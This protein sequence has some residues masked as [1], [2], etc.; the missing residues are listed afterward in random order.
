MYWRAKAVAAGSIRSSLVAAEELSHDIFVRSR[1]GAP[2]GN[3]FV[4]GH[5]GGLNLRFF[6]SLGRSMPF[7]RPKPP[8]LAQ[9][10]DGGRLPAE[11]DYL[12]W[13]GWLWTAGRLHGH[14]GNSTGHGPGG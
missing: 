12:V 4:V 14:V 1:A 11:V 6:S 8:Q 7:N 9:R 2:G 5:E 13:L 3:P 10:N